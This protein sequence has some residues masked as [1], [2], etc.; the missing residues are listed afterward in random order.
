MDFKLFSKIL[1]TQL[2][3]HVPAWVN[4]YQVGFVPGREARDNTIKALNLNH[5]LTSNQQEG[6]FLAMDAEKVF[7]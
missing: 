7:N 2:S 6:F 5:L 1:A 3:Y 4:L